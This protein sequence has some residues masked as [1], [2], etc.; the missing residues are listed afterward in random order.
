VDPDHAPLATGFLLLTTP[1]RAAILTSS[2]LA[3]GVQT[4]KSESSNFPRWTAVAMLT[5][6]NLGL[7]FFPAFII[8]PFK[9]QS[10]LGL[11]FA[12]HVK[13]FAP[14]ASLIV[15]TG[16]LILAIHLWR[17][18]RWLGRTGVVVAITLSAATAVMVR[19]N[20]FEWMFQPIPRAGFSS[21]NDIK[22]PDSEM[23]MSVRIGN[24]VRAYPVRQMA[25]HHV[26][27]D[28]IGAEPIVVTY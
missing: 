16:V 21:A 1:F 5:V 12:I 11:M 17:E 22:L 14:L 10:S 8:R 7:F 2:Y 3:N 23:V 24:D 25:Y 9:Y 18:S 13:Q 15:A 26:L 28:R 19:L 27:N 6:V 20:Y 4:L